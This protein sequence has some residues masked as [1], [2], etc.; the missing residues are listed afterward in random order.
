[1]KA[2]QSRQPRISQPEL[3]KIGRRLGAISSE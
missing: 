2:S 3:R 1:V